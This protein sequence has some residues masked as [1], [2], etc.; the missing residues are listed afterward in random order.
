[1]ALLTARSH[2]LRTEEWTFE[3]SKV[4]LRDNSS[5]VAQLRSVQAAA[6][7]RLSRFVPASP[8]GVL[9]AQH[10]V[11][12]ALFGRPKYFEYLILNPSGG[13]WC[14]MNGIVG[15]T[16]SKEAA[17]GV[18]VVATQTHEI[19][20][21]CRFDGR[22]AVMTTSGSA[23][24]MECTWDEG[25][26]SADFDEGVVA[27]RQTQGRDERCLIQGQT[28]DE[29][30]GGA[31]LRHRIFS[32][33]R[34]LAEVYPEGK[35][36]FSPAKMWK[37]LANDTIRLIEY[38]ENFVGFVEKQQGEE[39]LLVALASSLALHRPMLPSAN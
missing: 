2:V 30:R 12:L 37:R 25:Y 10:R 35:W 39:L 7:K 11:A 15:H 24:P 14:V 18:V 33:E 21:E 26:A 20:G 38:S 4:D 17:A 36:S 1:M 28:T 32:G 27:T 29:E 22:G 31:E 6:R 16:G 5:I 8:G 19:L 23:R 34:L 13:Y 9:D 3:G